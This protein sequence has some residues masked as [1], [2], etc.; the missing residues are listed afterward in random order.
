MRGKILVEVG[1]VLS[2]DLLFDCFGV[3]NSIN[4][5]PHYYNNL[6]DG[7]AYSDQYESD[8]RKSHLLQC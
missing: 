1:G 7:H 4:I 8:D 3:V 2:N 6:A 5:E